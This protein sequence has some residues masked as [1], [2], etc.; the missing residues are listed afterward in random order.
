MPCPDLPPLNAHARCGQQDQSYEFRLQPYLPLPR[1]PWAFEHKRRK[2]PCR[3]GSPIPMIERSGPSSLGSILLLSP[4]LNEFVIQPKDKE[5][6]SPLPDK[7]RVMI[8][9]IILNAREPAIEPNAAP[10]KNKSEGNFAVCCSMLL[11]TSTS[12]CYWTWS[13]LRLGFCYIFVCHIILLLS[14]RRHVRGS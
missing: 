7:Q 14:D 9:P 13:R 6:G 1:K 10:H 12:R 8:F 3:T 11:A 4:D 5:R 2:L